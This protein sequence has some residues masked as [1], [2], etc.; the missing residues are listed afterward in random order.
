MFSGNMDIAARQ[1]ARQPGGQS[2]RKSA[3]QPG[4]QSA[5][6]R[7]PTPPACTIHPAQHRLGQCPRSNPST[8]PNTRSHPAYT[9]HPA[10]HQEPSQAQPNSVKPSQE[11]G[12]AESQPGRQSG[13]LPST[14]RPHLPPAPAW[15]VPTVCVETS[16]FLNLQISRSPRLQIS[17]SP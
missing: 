17:T 9:I 15:A 6:C 1:P 2:G 13:W 11:A 5:L 12:Q 8:Q 16:R 4:G 10:Q 7:P 3:W 14:A